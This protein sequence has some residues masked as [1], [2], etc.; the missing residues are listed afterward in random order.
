VIW[1]RVT[2]GSRAPWPNGEVRTIDEESQYEFMR[3]Q[4][5]V[6]ARERAP[7]AYVPIGPMEWHGPHLAVGLDMLH[8]YAMAAEAVRLSGGVVLPPLPLGTETYTD[9]ERLRHRGFRGDERVFG[10]DYPGFPLPSLYAEE[11]A[12][13]VI[14]GEVVRALK[15]QAFRVIVI[16]NGHGAPNHRATLLRIA[17]EQTE[18]GRTAVLLTG[19]FYDTAYREHA[20]IGETSF[21]L[22]HHPEG[23]ELSA[24]PPLPKPL[25]YTDYGILDPGTIIGEPSPGFAVSAEHDPRH[26]SAERGWQDVAAEARSIAAKARDALAFLG[27]A[28]VAGTPAAAQERASAGRVPAPEV[29]YE[30]MRPAQILEARA[31]TP[32]AY[33]PIGPLEWHGPHLPYGVDPLHAHVVAVACARATGGV[34]LP[35][36]PLGT[37]TLIDSERLRYRGFAGH[38]RIIGMDFP[39]FPLS[40]LYVEESALGVIVREILLGIVRQAFRVIVMVNGHGAPNHRA[41]LGRLAAEVSE[42]GRV[43]VLLAGALVDTRVRGHAE[44][45]ETSYMLAYYPETVDLSAL[46]PLP[47]PIVTQATGV[48]DQPTLAGSPAADFSVGPEQDPRFAAADRGREDIASE[49]QRIAARVRDAL[50]TVCAR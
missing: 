24:L 2:V 25:R 14:V 11:S 9:P 6:S 34:V 3:P 27:A 28:T 12:M 35:M 29:R 13:G 5:I 36:L 1:H 39:G 30:F 19:Y 47:Q 16:V 44:L 49:V 26:A 8:A 18:P 21:L 20:A 48:L 10:M 17:N 45:R 31:R 41:L 43:A 40:S 15:R 38:E 50:T 23:V 7:I 46:P 32:V 22:A 33:L 42:P 37:E 4:Q